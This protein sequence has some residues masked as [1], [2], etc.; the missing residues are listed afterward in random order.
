MFL[1]IDEAEY[2]STGDKGKGQRSERWKGETELRGLRRKKQRK[3]ITSAWLLQLPLNPL[4]VNRAKTA[5]ASNKQQ[6]ASRQ[7]LFHKTVKHALPYI[8]RP[9]TQIKLHLRYNEPRA[10]CVWSS[11]NQEDEIP[12]GRLRAI[13]TQ[14]TW[15]KTVAHS[16]SCLLV[17]LESL[18]VESVRPPVALSNN[19]QHELQMNKSTM[20]LGVFRGSRLYRVS[21]VHWCQILDSLSIPSW[22]PGD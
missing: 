11:L 8:E 6:V 18:D 12:G 14:R 17:S 2:W 1:C 4:N 21:T 7:S 20:W 10:G 5:P 3:K 9:G 16:H 15:I 22:S 13:T 19:R